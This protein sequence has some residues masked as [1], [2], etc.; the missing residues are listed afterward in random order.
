MSFFSNWN[1]TYFPFCVCI[2]QVLLVALRIL[3]FLITATIRM[4]VQHLLSAHVQQPLGKTSKVELAP[5]S[6]KG[7][8]Q[9]VLI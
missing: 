6:N 1:F 9:V 8:L 2:V 5:V 3:I 4:S 7:R